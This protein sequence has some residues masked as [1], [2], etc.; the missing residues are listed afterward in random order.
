VNF[1]KGSCSLESDGQ[2]ETR[3]EKALQYGLQGFMKFNWIFE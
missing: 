1:S 2:R 3:K